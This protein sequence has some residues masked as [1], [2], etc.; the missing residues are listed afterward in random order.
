MQ[1]VAILFLVLAA[2]IAGCMSVRLLR[3]SY[4]CVVEEYLETIMPYWQWILISVVIIL[5]ALAYLLRQRIRNRL[6]DCPS[7]LR[8]F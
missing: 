7:I 5:A 3:R 6:C 2:L 1:V 8:R 4:V